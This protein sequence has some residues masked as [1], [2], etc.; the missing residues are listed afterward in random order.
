MVRNDARL[1]P[2]AIT[3]PPAARALAMEDGACMALPKEDVHQPC[4][5]PLDHDREEHVLGPLDV[6]FKD[7]V[8]LC[9]DGAAQPIEEVDLGYAKHRAARTRDRRRDMLAVR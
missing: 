7:H 9:G 8:V 3:Q 5:V 2:Q 6:H 4:E 1:V